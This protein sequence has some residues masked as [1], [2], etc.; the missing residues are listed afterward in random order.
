MTIVGKI[1]VFAN[2]VFAL[3]AGGLLMVVFFTST[4]WEAENKK[5]VA[6]AQAIAADRDQ[7]VRDFDTAQKSFEAKLAAANKAQK[8]AEDN[9]KAKDRELALTREELA[10]LKQKGLGADAQIAGT[11][12]ASSAR[13]K[14]VQELTQSNEELRGK[15]LALVADN[16]KERALRIQA[17]VSESTARTRAIQMEGAMKDLQRELQR[18]TSPT[19]TVVTRKKGEKNPP[20][21]NIEGRIVKADPESGLVS[22]SIG[23]DAGLVAGHTLEVFRLSPIPEQSKYLGTIE[24]LSVRPHEAVGRPTKALATPMQPGDRVA[25]RLLVGR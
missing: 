18:K 2:L 23:S 17:E 24:I 15:M 14:Q 16:Q 19:T 13:S 25:S 9:L 8:D 21:D 11:E 1:L 22:L 20:L 12:A 5:S 3:V 7:T 4:N 10:T 6:N